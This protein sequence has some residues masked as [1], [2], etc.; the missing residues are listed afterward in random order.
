MRE[1]VKHGRVNKGKLAEL[2]ALRLRSTAEVTDST[3]NVSIM[4]VML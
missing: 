2:A 1:R 4:V 3:D